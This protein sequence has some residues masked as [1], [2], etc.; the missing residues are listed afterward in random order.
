MQSKVHRF[1]I[2]NHTVIQHHGNCQVEGLI[3]CFLLKTNTVI[4][5]ISIL[6]KHVSDILDVAISS[7]ISTI[8]ETINLI[9]ICEQWH[10]I[11]MAFL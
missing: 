10:K 9:L 4:A 5:I 7:G 1:R 6:Q 8:V 3:N 2:I 11:R